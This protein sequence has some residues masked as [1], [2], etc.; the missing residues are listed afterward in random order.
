VVKH[1]RDTLGHADE[2]ELVVHG[3]TQRIADVLDVAVQMS[4]D[5]LLTLQLKRMSEYKQCRKEIAPTFMMSG[6][7]GRASRRD[8]RGATM[9]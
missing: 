3:D 8:W 5:V 7:V 6:R 2:D 4:R 9:L 1:Q